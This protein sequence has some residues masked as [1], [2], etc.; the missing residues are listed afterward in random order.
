MDNEILKM[1]QDIRRLFN[2]V[3]MKK[4]Y[5]DVGEILLN[6]IMQQFETEGK[7]FTGKE[8]E[9][10]A[11]STI[12]QRARKG[13]WPGNKLRVT[14]DLFGSFYSDATASGVTI[15]NNVP[16]AK[17]LQYGTKFMPDRPFM[18][19]SEKQ[20]PQEVWNEMAEAFLFRMLE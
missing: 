3:D 16:Y 5:N 4:F 12:M 14:G 7:Y 17:F 11:S 9:E 10:L 6:A 1:E 19:T 20:I 2:S 15:S 18:P 8:W 13:K